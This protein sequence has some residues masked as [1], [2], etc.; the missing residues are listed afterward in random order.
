MVVG[1]AQRAAAKL[2]AAAIDIPH[3]GG[4]EMRTVNRRFGMASRAGLALALVLTLLAGLATVASPAQAQE[5][6][7]RGQFLHASTDIGKVEVHLNGNEVLDE[8][9][10]GTVSDWID[11]EPGAM[12]VTITADR[13]GFNWVVFDSVYPISAGNDYNFIIS[14]VLVMA[15]PITRTPLAEGNARVQ[16][17]HASVDTPAVDVA[18][19]GGDTLVSGL[20][21]SQRSDEVDVPAGSYDLEFRLGGSTDVALSLPGTTLEAG[22]VYEFVLMGDPNSDDK[23]LAVTPLVDT[24]Q[25]GTPSATPAATPTS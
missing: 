25:P 21:Y 18:I 13:A 17:V 4:N 11:L 23:P 15:T 1:M 12:R 8:Y 7:T 6:Q 19:A 3:G 24:V 2:V 20:A 16:L 22:M 9:E 14:D 10:Y 5:I